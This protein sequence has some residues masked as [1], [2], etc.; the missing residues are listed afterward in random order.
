M[1]D[2]S[3]GRFRRDLAAG[4][5]NGAVRVYGIKTSDDLLTTEPGVGAIGDHDRIL[6]SLINGHT[7]HAGMAWDLH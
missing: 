5:Q 6:G 1:Q 4:Q 2:R 3:Q 7:R